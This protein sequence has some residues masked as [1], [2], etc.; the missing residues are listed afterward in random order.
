MEVAD[1]TDRVEPSSSDLS[2]GRENKVL[3]GHAGWP[4]QGREVPAGATSTL[5][6]HPVEWRRLPLEVEPVCT[7]GW[8]APDKGFGEAV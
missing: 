8:S 5:T 3:E 6:G 4:V 2:S 7:A 1:S